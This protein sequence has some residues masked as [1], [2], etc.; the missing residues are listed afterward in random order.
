[1]K[2]EAADEKKTSKRRRERVQPGG[3][4]VMRET[5][6]RKDD[7]MLRRG[8]P[9]PPSRF[10]LLTGIKARSDESFLICQS[11]SCASEQRTSA[12]E[13][14]YAVLSFDIPP[15]FPCFLCFQ[16][17]GRAAAADPPPDFNPT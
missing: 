6:S 11:H 10:H 4:G 16:R 12:N 15:S 5:A 7:L 17:G 13:N 1:M 2:T 3:R 9:A 14:E 8:E